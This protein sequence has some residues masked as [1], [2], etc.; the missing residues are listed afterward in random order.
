MLIFDMFVRFI[1]K[2]FIKM[3]WIGIFLDNFFLENCKTQ[4]AH[5]RDQ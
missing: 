4:Q 1:I 5:I 3:D 2:S